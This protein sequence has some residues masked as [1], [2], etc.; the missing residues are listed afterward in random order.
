VDTGAPLKRR[1]QPVIE[2]L[3]RDEPVIAMHGPRTVGKSTMMRALA[4]VAGRPVVDLDDRETRVSVEDNLSAYVS[5]E[6]PVFIDEYQHFPP[7]LDAIK[8]EL[9]RNL[10]PGRFVLTGSTRYSSLPAAAQSLTGRLHIAALW[11]LSQ[12]EIDGVEERFV[13]QLLDDPARLVDPGTQ[14]KTSRRDYAARIL[15]GGLPLAVARRG[16]SRGR[17]FD[18]YVQLV[19]ERDVIEL[20]R[21]RQRE[22]M[23]QLLMR[24]ASQSAQVLNVARA[25]A[26]LG[27]DGSTAEEYVRL[28][29]AAF[30]IHRLPAWGTTLRARVSAKPKL[31]L[32]DSGVAGRMLG[33]DESRLAA[34]QPQAMTQ[35][36]YLLETFCVGEL[37]KQTS[38]IDD[39][40]RT[41]H[42]R[43]HDGDEVDLV[44]ERSDGAV[45]GV[46]IKA[47][48][49]TSSS[50]F[51]GLRKLRD[52]LGERFLGGVVLHLGR[53]GRCHA[54]RLYALPVD[55]LWR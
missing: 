42:W 38:W 33:V 47:G 2:S 10:E 9:N 11:P 34:A 6:A 49:A 22:K 7:L 17:W 41:G 31:H 16:A 39:R 27:I 28:L 50:S 46:E 15:R 36:G 37:M 40:V 51:R 4:E 12:G 18:D 19:V 53:Y 52:A 30:L 23:P 43:T 35:L 3:L 45:A 26:D 13:E 24:L 20:S 5:G 1:L 29:E 8:A 25:A 48:E 44:L 55:R 14:S 32:V 21:I 54:E